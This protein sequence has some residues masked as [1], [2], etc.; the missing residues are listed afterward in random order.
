MTFHMQVMKIV[1]GPVLRPRI[2]STCCQLGWV[3][4]SDEASSTRSTNT[5]CVRGALRS[6]LSLLVLM[7]WSPGANCAQ[8]AYYSIHVILQS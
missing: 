1:T 6:D 7:L 4:S 5:G 8:P 2:E 3:H